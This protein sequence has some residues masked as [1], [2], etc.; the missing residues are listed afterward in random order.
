MIWKNKKKG[1][2]RE[3]A[4]NQDVLRVMHLAVLS[5]M[6]HEFVIATDGQQVEHKGQSCSPTILRK[7]STR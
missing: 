3:G 4:K 6:Y 2:E 7:E 5:N 1:P